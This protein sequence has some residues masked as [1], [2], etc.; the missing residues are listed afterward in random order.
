MQR[1]KRCLLTSH[2]ND[3]SQEIKTAHK[4]PGVIL[5]GIRYTVTVCVDCRQ[6][7]WCV[8][9]T[10]WLY[11]FYSLISITEIR[12]SS[13]L[14][15]KRIRSYTPMVNHSMNIIHTLYSIQCIPNWYY[16]VGDIGISNSLKQYTVFTV[17]SNQNLICLIH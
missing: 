12:S 13:W 4:I 3:F 1:S 8:K 6:R 14:K 16:Q 15:L 2:Q 7:R 17:L 11:L 10:V 5:E 9:R